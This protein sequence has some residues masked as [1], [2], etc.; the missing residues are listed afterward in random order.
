MSSCAQ[1]LISNRANL[2]RVVIA[3]R[4][5]DHDTYA[6]LPHLQSLYT[7]SIKVDSLTTPEATVVGNLL[8]PRDIRML[9]RRC[10]LVTP[11]VFWALSSGTAAVTQLVVWESS[12]VHCHEL[13]Q[14]QHLIL[15][16][17]VRPH[18]D[19]NMTDFKP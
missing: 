19:V 12:K 8:A 5:W 15:L 4:S 13:Q 1:V 6:A 10:D 11:R 7:I 9:I 2:R 3:S 14:M 16:A 17:V 18:H